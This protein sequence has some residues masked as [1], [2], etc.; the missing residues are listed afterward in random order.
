MFKGE[1][2]CHQAS[3]DLYIYNQNLLKI[4]ARGKRKRGGGEQ[5]TIPNIRMKQIERHK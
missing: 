3:A 2:N 1:K 5:E 4:R